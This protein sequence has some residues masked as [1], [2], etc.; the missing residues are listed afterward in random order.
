MGIEVKGASILGDAKTQFLSETEIVTSFSEKVVAEQSFPLLAGRSSPR[1]TP[2]G[3]LLFRISNADAI[4]GH[5]R[6]RPKAIRGKWRLWSLAGLLS[7]SVPVQAAL[8]GVCTT[9]TLTTYTSGGSCTI[10]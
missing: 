6:D 4:R 1:S 5:K 10:G 2:L 8:V 3:C 7:I 9:A